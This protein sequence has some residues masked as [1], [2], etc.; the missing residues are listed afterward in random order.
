MLSVI[1]YLAIFIGSVYFFVALQRVRVT[2]NGILLTGMNKKWQ[3]MILFLLSMLPVIL[4]YG[5][6]YGI[7]ADYFAYLDIYNLLHKTPF[8]D[9]LSYHLQ[10]DPSYYL[11]IGYYLLNRIAT[12]YV[13]LQFLC[14]ILCLG[15]V[16]TVV[17]KYRERLRVEEAI[18]VFLLLDF[19]YFMNGVRYILALSFLLCAY[20]ELSEKKWVRFI[21]LVLCASLFHKTSLFCLLFVFLV[22]VEDARPNIIRNVVFILGTIFLPGLFSV[23]FAVLSKIPAF[24]RYVSTGLYAPTQLSYSGGLKWTIHFIPVFVPILLKRKSIKFEDDIRVFRRIAYM[25]IP[26]RIV[27]MFNPWY[28]RLCRLA[29]VSQVILI[30][31][32]LQKLSDRNE[33]VLFTAYYA[34]WYVFYFVYYTVALDGSGIPY[35]SVL[36]R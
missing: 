27:S 35:V 21:I 19:V 16:F 36:F 31:S 14:I 34:V 7:G 5:L 32:F 12:S 30:P 11:E 24:G 18:L 9:Y 20:S 6:R 15:V 13:V 8:K 4:L 28:G 3:K 26:L 33:K 10:G 22:D 17:N 2:C 25:E 23:L 29:Q 1:L